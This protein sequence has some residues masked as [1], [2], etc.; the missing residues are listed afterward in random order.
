MNT[1]TQEHI[2]SRLNQGKIGQRGIDLSETVLSEE[3]TNQWIKQPYDP[4]RV[5]I[6]P[7]FMTVFE[8]LHRIKEDEIVLQPEFQRNLVWDKTRQSRLIESLLLNIPLPA[9]YLD[10]S[11]DDAWLVIDGLQRLYTLHRFCNQNKLRLVG[12]EFPD[13]HQFQ[14]K[15]FKELPRNLQRR[16]ETTQL[17]FHTIKPGTPKNVKFR[18]F[19]RINTGGADS[20]G[21]PSQ[22][23]S[24]KSN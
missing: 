14:G 17:Y 23:V 4:T 8:V 9:F 22:F 12:L 24:R 13:M 16:I 18:I 10:I 11:N 20:P 21:N 5:Q 6:D 15:T 3:S 19:S 7:K 2:A 1:R